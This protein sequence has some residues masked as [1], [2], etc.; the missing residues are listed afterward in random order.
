M[1]D[2]IIKEVWQTKDRIAKQYN[3]D[4]SVLAAELQ[5]QQQQSGRKV[6]NLTKITTDQAKV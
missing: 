1:T 5:K 4:I 3:Y 2:E 6:V